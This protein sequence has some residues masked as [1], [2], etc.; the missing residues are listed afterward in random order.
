M[1]IGIAPCISPELLSVLHRMGHG[2]EIVLGDAFFCGDT[3]GQRVIRA[4]GIR[5][6][7]LLGGI[8]SLISLDDMVTDSLVIMD[9][10]P[11]DALDPGMV[12]SYRQAIE[13]RWPHA[14]EFARMERYA[15]YDRARKAFAVVMTG[16]T[17]KYGN[18]IIRK[19]VI[20]VSK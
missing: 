16:E 12:S 14:P 2:D 10:T 13:R 4:D 5:I 15:F 9:P 7:E 1:L 8:L 3:F 6:P 17:V 18:I 20:P 11:P 19:G